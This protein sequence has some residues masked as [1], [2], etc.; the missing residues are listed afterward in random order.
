[1]GITC[2]TYLV[3]NHIISGHC[4]VWQPCGT[5]RPK[6]NTMS[7]NELFGANNTNV[8]ANARSLP[9]TA[10]LTTVATAAAHSILK[11]MEADIETYRPIIQASATDTKVMD[12][13]LDEMKPYVDIED[14]S[15]LRNLDDA[16]VESMLKSQQSKRSRAK[17]KTMTLDN[18]ITLLT[19]TIAEEILRDI[20]NKP[21]AAGFQRAAGT[22]DYTGA[23][24]EMLAADQ[25]ALR[26]EIRNI[27]SKKSIMK[28]KADFSES[29]ERWLALLKAEQQLKDLRVGGHTTTVV[30]VD[31]T[32]DAISELLNG[33]D[34]SKMKSA[35]A[36]ELL[37]RIAQMA[38]A[39]EAPIDE[40]TAEEIQ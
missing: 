31:K 37:E 19:A 36:H 20:Y 4:I 33:K 38:I 12:N 10:E 7:I 2:G 28:S 8:T 39:K 26:R 27:Q 5:T 9:G 14:D 18:Y 23:Q 1:M 35:E 15:I 30:E 17:S 6:G 3:G 32:K 22:V 21:K 34:I 25:E 16:T 11:R 29:D 40:T 13:L 24:L